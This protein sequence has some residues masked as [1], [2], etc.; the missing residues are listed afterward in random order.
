MRKRKH[1]LIKIIAAVTSGIILTASIPASAAWAESNNIITNSTF[2]YNTT[3]WGT[4]KES[5]GNA[6]LSV[7]SGRLA[8]NITSLGT[9]NYSVQVYYD[10]GITKVICT[11]IARDGML[12]GPAIDLYKE[13][14]DEIPFLYIIASGGVSSIED[15]EKLSEAGIPAVIF[16]KAI[17]EGKIQLKDLLR[18]T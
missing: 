7:D 5:G 11:D 6:S 3:G 13:I 18:F 4:Y 9:L 17:Y 2:D 8:L 14:R 10:K 16:G 15:I 12:Q 1:T